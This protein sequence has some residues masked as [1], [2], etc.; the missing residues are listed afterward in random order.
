M[1]E[2]I[3]LEVGLYTLVGPSVMEMHPL[4]R[5]GMH[6]KPLVLLEWINPADREDALS[7]IEGMHGR[8]IVMAR[9]DKLTQA[10]C[11][12]LEAWGGYAVEETMN[13]YKEGWWRTRD[14]GVSKGGQYNLWSPRGFKF[15]LAEILT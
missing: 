4:M 5:W 2:H 1:I 6:D 10:D 11:E 12:R 9:P 8:V 13:T 7:R 3:A 14:K 15:E